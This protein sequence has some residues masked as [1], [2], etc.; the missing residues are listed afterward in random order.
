MGFLFS[1]N[2]CTTIEHDRV[3][4]IIFL[5]IKRHTID[6]IYDSEILDGWQPWK[7]MVKGAHD[8]D[9]LHRNFVLPV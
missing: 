9:S 1:W 2:G 8:I 5:F 4:N 7:Y 6:K 3:K